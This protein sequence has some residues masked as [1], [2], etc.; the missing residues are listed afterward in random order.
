MTAIPSISLSGV[1]AAQMRLDAAANNIANG[2]TPGFK[3]DQVVQQT[4]ERAGVVTVV[5]KAQEVGPALAADIIEQMQ[6]SLTYRAN[7]RSIQTD[8]RMQG[9]LLDLKA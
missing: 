3:R 2:Q 6:A 8:Q 1:H 9:S 5:G 7:L 4:Q